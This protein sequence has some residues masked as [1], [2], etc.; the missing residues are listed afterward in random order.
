MI[1]ERGQSLDYRGAAAHVLGA[2]RSEAAVPALWKAAEDFDP[3]GDPFHFVPGAALDALAAIGPPDLR[4]RLVAL[5][6]KGT[7]HDGRVAAWLEANPGR[8]A[9]PVLRGAL[10]RWDAREG[11]RFS[12]ERR[13]IAAALAACER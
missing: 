13:R 4:P 6:G 7:P 3:G 8:D 10:A 1:G 5:L 9:V 2:L 12:W 11:G